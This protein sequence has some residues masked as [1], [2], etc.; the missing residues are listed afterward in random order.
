MTAPRN[1]R[2]HN[3]QDKARY[4]REGEIREER[5]IRMM[6]LHS[7]LTVYAN[8]EKAAT[9]NGKYAADLWVPG[10]G[11]CDLKTQ[12]TPFFTS[13]KKSG[14]PP[15]KAVTFNSKDVDRYSR[16]YENIGIFFWVNWLNNEHDRYGTCRYRWGVY[17][18]RLHDIYEIINS[19]VSSNHAYLGRKETTSDHA[20]AARGMNREGNA[21]D[22]WL[23]SVEW[24]E[25]IVVSQHNPWN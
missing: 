5:F 19:K 25:P 7:H 21:L 4:C 6:N 20:L 22:S 14:I 13:Q 3:P 10:Y 23:L 17:F 15:D 12:E 8:P 9:S 24:M 1:L 2:V 18:I 16:I 11:Y